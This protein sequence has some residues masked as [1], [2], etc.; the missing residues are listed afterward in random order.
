MWGAVMFPR[1]PLL[2]PLAQQ[3]FSN[4]SRLAQPYLALRHHSMRCTP[5]SWQRAVLSS[6][7]L[8]NQLSHHRAHLRV[9]TIISMVLVASQPRSRSPARVCI[10]QRILW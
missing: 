6:I 3:R 8:H 2:A 4:S 10:V 9:Q 5:G 1:V 7:L